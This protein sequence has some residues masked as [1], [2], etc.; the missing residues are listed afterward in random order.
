MTIDG[1]KDI[2]KIV[3]GDIVLT[4]NEVTKRNEYNKVTNLFKHNPEDINDKLYTLSFDDNTTLEVTSAHRFYIKRNNK[5]SWIAAEDLK[6]NDKVLY[7]NG[8]YHK[9]T[10]I[11][12]TELTSPVYNITVENNH[13]YYVGDN[14]ILVHNVKAPGA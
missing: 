8:K 13:N 6:V 11:S 7:A 9:I 12:D 3:A 2:D 14:G 1:Y 4:Y 10:A 5:V